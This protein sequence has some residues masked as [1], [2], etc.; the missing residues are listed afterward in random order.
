MSNT[1]KITCPS[2]KKEFDAGNAFNLHFEKAKI[3]SEKDIKNAKFETDKYK[4]QLENNKKEIE[5]VKADAV[6]KQKKKHLKNINL[7]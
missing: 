5:K 2:C 1:F 6:K 3:A 4:S 7:N